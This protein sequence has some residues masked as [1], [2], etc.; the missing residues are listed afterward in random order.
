MSAAAT[1]A[2]VPK[3]S[4]SL[5]LFSRLCN[6]PEGALVGRPLALRP[7]QRAIL[8]N[9]DD[10]RLRRLIISM[11]RKNG[12]SALIAFLV[13]AALCGP[14]AQQNG[15]VYSAARSRDQAS[16]VFRLAKNMIG[17]SPFLTAKLKIRDSIKEIHCTSTGVTY[18]AISA[19]AKQAHGYSPFMVIHDELGQ[20]RGQTDDLYDALETSGGAQSRF[21]S[22]I[23]STQA[24]TD[25][26]LLSTLIDDALA[27]PQDPSTRIVLYAAPDG[28]DPFE[29]QTWAMCNPALGD[30]RSLK[31]VQDLAARAKRMPSQESAFL[32]LY[33]NRR[34]SEAQSF[35]SPSVWGAGARPINDALF[36]EEP[37]F[38]G[39][40]LSQTTALTA[41][42]LAVRDP[43]SD[44]HH[45]KA[46]FFMPAATLAERA[47]TDRAPYVAWAERGLIEAVPGSVIDLDYVVA[48][49][50]D[51]TR[52]MHLGEIRYDRWRIEEFKAAAARA[53]ARIEMIPHGQG[54]AAMAPSLDRFERLA[55]EGKLVHGANPVLTWNFANVIIRKDP[56]GN[57]KMDRAQVNMARIDGAVAAVMATAIVDAERIDGGRSIYTTRARP[58]GILALGERLASGVAADRARGTPAGPAQ[59]RLTPSPA[60]G[61]TDFYRGPDDPLAGLDDDDGD[62]T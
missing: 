51:L 11:P 62:D 39:L 33:L 46:H 38:G 19:D 52:G 34:I 37:V 5:V 10:P 9:F 20:V 57:R 2:K 4:D 12:K 26:A 23:I 17:Q 28:A 60:P 3:L 43:A 6:V 58:T 8:R 18:R 44:E 29:P 42:V 53:G 55:V 25:Q 56:A 15:Q 50:V 59:P 54:Y 36:Y 16:I 13:L 49:I 47:A 41:L 35:I 31:D 1:A 21:T 32:N 48:R 24:P 14:L 27:N 22:V 7:W 61:R 40:D 30:F 45:L